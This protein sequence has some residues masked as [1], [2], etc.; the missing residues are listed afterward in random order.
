[1]EGFC[2]RS[3]LWPRCFTHTHTHTHTHTRA[4]ARTNTHKY[5]NT[6][7]HARTH[8]YTH[9]RT[10]THTQ[11]THNTQTTHTHTG[12]ERKGGQNIIY[13]QQPSSVNKYLMYISTNKAHS[14][15]VFVLF[16]CIISD[17]Q[18][19]SCIGDDSYKLNRTK[20]KQNTVFLHQVCLATAN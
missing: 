4:H 15:Y 5:T 9:K 3:L 11:H 1:M 18:L 14:S 8:K 17:V 19:K 20:H 2:L 10:H 6:H 12:R 13:T 16:F 7:A